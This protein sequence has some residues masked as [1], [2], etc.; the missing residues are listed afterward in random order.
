MAFVS[1]MYCVTLLVLALWPSQT[2]SRLLNNE[3]SMVAK[4]EQWM[5]FHE[6]IY[7]ND[8]EKT[9][10]FKIFNENVQLIEEL[11]NMN[12]G[13]TL[14]VNAFADLTNEEFRA[15]RTGYK[16]QPMS[17]PKSQ[18]FRYENVTEVSSSIDWRT[19][20]A[21]T[22]IKDQGECGC[23]WAFSTVAATEGLNYLKE[24]KLLSLSEQQLVDCDTNNEG[25]EGGLMDTAFDFIYR[26]GG[27]TTES[28]YPYTATDGTCNTEQA[29]L[30]AASISGYEDV[31]VDDEAALLKAV[32]HQPV[33]VGVDGG[34]FDFQFYSGGVFDG[35]C[36]TDLD[37]A[38]AVIGYGS[39]GEGEEYWLVKNSWGTM[40]GENGYMRIKRGADAKEGLCGIAMMASY[41]IA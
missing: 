5:A 20:G 22:P 40:W 16:R 33:S 3:P 11:N 21:V 1:K 28:N 23:C 15:S 17:K 31:P 35:E 18:S 37:H 8:V 34:G 26:R 27:L 7:E 39:A 30:Q 12:R 32:T 29:A 14:G 25:C 10:R 19:R 24:G 13:F 2:S 41:P 6:R 36:G 38:V 9:R 4:H